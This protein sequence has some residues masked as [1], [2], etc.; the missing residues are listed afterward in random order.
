[1]AK[2]KLIVEGGKAST[3]P[4]MAQTL[5]PLKMDMSKIISD[6]NEKTASFKGVKVPVEVD[7]NEKEKTYEI[8]VKSPPTSELIKKELGIKLGSGTP[9]K[10][11]IANMAIKQLI[12]VT[13]VKSAGMFVNNLRSAL[14]A[15]AGSCN[16]LG[17]LIE[18]QES[19]EFNKSLEAGK[20]DEE[21]NSE[22]T[23]VSDDKIKE[24]KVQLDLIQIELN[25][26][27]AKKKG[28]GEEKVDKKEGKEEETK[29]EVK[30]EPKKGEKK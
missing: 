1:M 19:S 9:D 8:T 6:I 27:F 3:T 18:G 2:I 5:G 16:S 11:K 14:K 10:K 12:N 25:K 28:K 23:E 17:V 4:A 13:N 7:V 29:E 30:E 24:L 20:Y 15:V 26:K 22:K 21:I